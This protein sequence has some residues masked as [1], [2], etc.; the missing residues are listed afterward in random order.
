MLVIE[1]TDFKFEVISDL[2]GHLEATMTLEVTKWAQALHRLYTVVTLYTDSAKVCSYGP[3][4]AP[5]PTILAVCPPA[6]CSLELSLL[7]MPLSL[8]FPLLYVLYPAVCWC[9]RCNFKDEL[10]NNANRSHGPL[11]QWLP[12]KLRFNLDLHLPEGSQP[13]DQLSWTT[14]NAKRNFLANPVFLALPCLPERGRSGV[15]TKNSIFQR[16]APTFSEEFENCC[17]KRTGE[18]EEDFSLSEI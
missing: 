11:T 5:T 6:L 4:D 9:F 17:G 18:K 2:R 10:S 14:L 8:V 1:V 12:E 15:G 7:Y 16:W 3:T 13:N